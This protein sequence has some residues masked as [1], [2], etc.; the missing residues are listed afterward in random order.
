MW[1]ALGSGD[2]HLT[3]DPPKVHESTETVREPRLAM[4]KTGWLDQ[5]HSSVMVLIHG[6]VAP[7]TF[8]GDPYFRDCWIDQRFPMLAF[9]AAVAL[10]VLLVLFP[11]P[12][13]KVQSPHIA[14]P[15]PQMELTWYSPERD[16]PTVM[17]VAR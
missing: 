8:L 4:E 16:L 9:T 13:W 14:A 12:I 3:D 2:L 10:Q 5:F 6:P 11:P 15:P 7:K 1:Q 17:P